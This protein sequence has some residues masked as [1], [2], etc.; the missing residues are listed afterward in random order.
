[1]PNFFDGM[2]TLQPESTSRDAAAGR[3]SDVAGDLPRLD[4]PIDHPRRSRSAIRRGAR[5]FFI[6]PAAVHALQSLARTFGTDVASVLLAAFKTLLF[7]YTGQPDIV[8]GTL[9][10]SE[11]AGSVLARS[12][13]QPAIFRTRISGDLVFTQLLAEV[14]QVVLEAPA[15]P[16]LRLHE[17]APG[18]GD[19][20][21]PQAAVQAMFNFRET[22]FAEPDPADCS[23][24]AEL[25]LS[26]DQ[27]NGGLCG[28]LDFDADLFEEE[29]IERMIGHFQTLVEGILD[30]PEQ[31]ISRLP[32]LTERERTQILTDWNNTATDY[33]SGKTIHELFEEQARRTPDRVALVFGREQLTFG[34]LDERANALAQRLRHCGVGPDVRV[35]VCMLRSINMVVT[36]YAIH[37]AGGAYVPIDPGYPADRIA[38][39]LE[40]AQVPLVLT[41]QCVRASLPAT[42]ARIL[43][44]DDPQE[45]AA[46]PA[47]N[48]SH[49]VSAAVPENL[50]YV[51]YTSGSTGK[52]KGVMVR[53]KNAVNFFTGMDNAI[54]REP[55]TWLA[56]TSI[57]F[58]ISVLELFWTLTRGFKVVIHA[59]D[60][61]ILRKFTDRT[62]PVDHLSLADEIRKHQVTHL[63]CTPSLA[64]MMLD[65]T[66]TEQAL[67]QVKT[68]LFGGEPMPPSLPAR[69]D[70]DARIFNMYGPTETTVWS[71]VSQVNRAGP[72]TIGRPI[73]NT[74]LYILDRNLQ[75][76]PARVP[77]ELYIAGDGVTRGYL[78][79]AELTNE[80]FVPEPFVQDVNARM[81]R[82][83]DLARFN[84]DGTIDFLGRMDNQ[85]KVRGHR[86]ELGEIESVLQQQPGIKECVV[87][88]WQAG[89]NDVRL[90]GYFVTDP[91]AEVQLAELRSALKSTL[92][93]YMVPST[94]LR[95]PVLPL[96]PNGKVDRKA[97][98]D[99]APSPAAQTASD[100]HPLPGAPEI[101]KTE[102]RGT[103][104]EVTATLPLTEAQHEIW[105][106]AQVSDEISCSFN[107]SVL[108]EIKGPL[109][110]R[111]L[112]ASIESLVQRHEALRATFAASGEEQL[113]HAR[114]SIEI[115]SLDFTSMPAES[116][117]KALDDL[118]QQEAGTPF[119]L[120]NGPLFRFKLAR[121]APRENVFLVTLHHIIC[122]GGSLGVVIG[123]LG[124]HYSAA[125]K[126]TAAPAPPKSYREFVAEQIAAQQSGDHGKTEAFWLERCSRPAP[127]LKLPVDREAPAR[128][129][130]SGGSCEVVLSAAATQ[131]IRKVS[132]ARCCSLTTTLLATW[133]LLLQRLT[134]QSEI[135][136]GLPMTVR[137][138]A[139]SERLVAH[140]VNFL[141]LQLDL[142]GDPPFNEHL[143]RVWNLLIGAIEHHQ[144]TLGSLL[145][146]LNGGRAHQ[147]LISVMFNVDCAD[148]A[149]DLA[150]CSAAVKP[151]PHGYSRF[152]LSLS[153]TEAE[154]LPIRCE[155]SAELFDR[156]TVENWLKDYEQLLSAAAANPARRLSQL[157]KLQF[158]KRVMEPAPA[159]ATARSIAVRPS[160]LASAVEAMTETEQKL[161]E[162]WREVVLIETVGRHESFF[163]VGGHSLLATKVTARIS[164]TFGI[165]LPVRFIF[166]SPTI[167]ELAVVIDR[168]QTDPPK[169][170]A[171]AIGRRTREADLQKLLGRLSQLSESELQNLIRNTNS[172]SK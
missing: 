123:E 57:S 100:G 126:G 7:R 37:K 99:P 151:N 8:V 152:D 46:V 54:G 168:M 81:Y 149:V 157:P 76:L 113:L 21:Q 10:R 132:A 92:P 59:D 19:N 12:P 163:D 165:N 11:T 131:A 69:M 3:A 87:S 25:H 94:F 134:G 104:G 129:K 70:W 16:A 53:H 106:G 137:E 15:H 60:P 112:F 114:M 75:P 170:A 139:D 62:T 74:R 1:M 36:L 39:V 155:Y 142:R 80:R 68:F 105:L 73:A 145:Q 117:Q 82:T 50:A 110:E 58:D 77:G 72:I 128:R 63:Q 121:M 166:E 159:A 51:I 88:V 120:V 30:N 144:I 148:A 79:R 86:I 90:V 141:P 52:P 130:F 103:K 48:S 147:P 29:T 40:D 171:P 5:Q 143:D 146:K 55:G 97:L 122:D 96:T 116:R 158:A 65:D 84:P 17:S 20:S 156:S 27:Q 43:A 109:D 18:T 89:P 111:R 28:E 67:R 162:I 47:N 150:G 23:G 161:A 138:G 95:L 125:I 66:D 108:V 115:A 124:E 164:K 33:P 169:T 14:R 172:T 64:G 119:D 133:Y 98:P 85:V 42:A 135:I 34:Q 154:R 31:S 61:A 83:G 167:A 4:L 32:L 91:G 153:A 127:A 6:N 107:Q 49:S 78:N 38:F 24:L 44:V 13:R 136:V 71:S 56:V 9:P 45:I 160:I 102:T 140:C 118:L 2:T 22:H 93:D 41:Q 26:F 101:V 35:A